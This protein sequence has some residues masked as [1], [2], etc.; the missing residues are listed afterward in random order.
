MN[1]WFWL[2]KVDMLGLEKNIFN[3]LNIIFQTAYHHEGGHQKCG[4][5]FSTINTILHLPT[6]PYTIHFD[7]HLLIFSKVL[8]NILNFNVIKFF[9]FRIHAVKLAL[10]III[11]YYQLSISKSFCNYFKHLRSSVSLAKL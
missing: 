9:V 7:V 2:H 11:T 5:L 1:R 6:S 8:R 3:S 10:P 4:I